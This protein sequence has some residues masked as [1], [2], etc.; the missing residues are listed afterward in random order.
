MTT[1]QIVALALFVF[2]YAAI[3]LEHRW[4]THKSGVGLALAG[5][6]WLLVATSGI[7][8]DH[9]SHA[10]EIAGAEVFGLIVFLLAAM[11]LVEVMLHFGFFDVLQEK[12]SKRG[13]DARKQFLLIAVLTFFL[14][15]LLDNLTVTI[16]M[17][18][19]ARRF[20][21][22]ELLYP[23]AAGIVVAANAGGAWSPIGDVTTIMLWLAEK[24]SAVDIITQAIIPAMV[25]AGVSVALI[26]R[27]VPKEPLEKTELKR[28]GLTRVKKIIIGMAFASFT[29][30]IGM[31]LIGLPPYMG[32][33]LGLGLVWLMIEVSQ[34]PQI[35]K[36]DGETR[37]EAM[38]SKTD[39]ASIKFFIGI[40]LAVSALA[41]LGVLEHI[42][43]LAFGADPSFNR[44]IMGNSMLGL[45]SA[46]V[47]NVPLTAIAIDVIHVHDPAVWVMLA[48]AVG[49]G[50]SALVIGSAAGV[51]AMGMVRGLNFGRYMKI[52]TVPVL[53]GYVAGIATWYLQHLLI[54]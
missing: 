14:S 48:L 23:V 33:L 24:F 38:L 39:L 43:T 25:L 7:E 36:L 27:H 18:Q 26:A 13:L 34:H 19:I 42:S 28:D 50:G 31:N 49:T 30:P 22:G 41:T 16:I 1:L 9:L 40:L 54:S 15:A 10:I 11:T 35:A 5:V 2:G 53:I 32:L 6:L 44:L 8:R 20:Y 12:L 3:T 17:I 52:A 51:V 45:F 47:D 46:I 21:K 4:R 29:L 37:V